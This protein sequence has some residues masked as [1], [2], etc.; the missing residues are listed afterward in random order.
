MK[1]FRNAPFVASVSLHALALTSLWIIHTEGPHAAPKARSYSSVIVYTPPAVPRSVPPRRLQAPPA[2]DL[3]AITPTVFRA[4]NI[5]EE[6]RP[7]TPLLE[8]PPQIP[9][10]PQQPVAPPPAPA[11]VAVAPPP[12][13]VQLGAFASQVPSAQQP[14]AK[15]PAGAAG[16][17]RIN[18]PPSSTPSR[19]PAIAGAFDGVQSVAGGAARHVMA[20]ATFDSA[21]SAVQQ[22]ARNSIRAGGFGDA[23]V[24]HM[25]AGSKHSAA[26]GAVFRPVEII[27]KPK[28]SYTE[29]ARRLGVEGEVIF[30]ALFTSSGHIRIL[31]TVKGL[32]HGLD[33]TALR[34][35]QDI[36]FRPAERDGQPVDFSAAVHIYFQLAR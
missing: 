17:D 13:Q 5:V 18:A 31:R 22:P 35:A 27:D 19:Q 7:K 24:A 36:R 12:K 14:A 23:T 11:A 20:E 28:P 1:G 8:L 30:E 32:G 33:E 6:I 26:S 9:V 21:P 25:P 15:A 16:F 4:P 29:E 2:H 3:A 10:T 34:A